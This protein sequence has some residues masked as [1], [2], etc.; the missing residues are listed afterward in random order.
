MINPPRV[1]DF[2]YVWTG[3]YAWGHFY[4]NIYFLNPE[5]SSHKWESAPG[6][7]GLTTTATRDTPLLNE[8]HLYKYFIL[9]GF[10]D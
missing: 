1:A 4:K 6:W 3:Y 5:T 8:Y 2:L 10:F 7:S 9:M